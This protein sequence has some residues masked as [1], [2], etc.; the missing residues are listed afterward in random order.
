MRRLLFVLCSISFLAAPLRAGDAETALQPMAVSVQAEPVKTLET[1]YRA[2]VTVGQEKFAFLIPEKFHT[3]GDPAQGKLQL[4]SLTGDTMISFSFIGPAPTEATDGGRERY[5]ELLSSR[6]AQGKILS[7]FTRP[8][9][10]RNGLGFD[11]EWKSP[12]GLLQ[13]TRAVY[14]PT[15]AGMLEVTLTTGTRNFTA[16]QESLNLTLGSLQSSV[17]GKLTVHH[18]A[19]AN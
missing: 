17:G 3:G 9:L 4:T 6:Y 13:K 15:A 12:A 18:I 2:Y 10:G 11:V 14:I 7:E 16:M 8:A 5:R 1:I 19:S